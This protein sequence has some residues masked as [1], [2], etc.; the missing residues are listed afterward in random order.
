MRLIYILLWVLPFILNNALFAQKIYFS[1]ESYTLHEPIELIIESP[2]FFNLPIQDVPTFKGLTLIGSSSSIKKIQ[3]KNHYFLHLLYKATQDGKIE[4]PAFKITAAKQNFHFSGKSLVLIQDFPSA[5]K[6]KDKWKLSPDDAILELQFNKPRV[7]VGELL[8]Q[9]VA[10]YIREELH[11]KIYFEPQNLQSLLQSLKNLYFWEETFDS[12]SFKI[13]KGVW[14]NGHKYQKFLLSRSYLYPLQAGS[15]H[16]EP[17][18]LIL[19]KRVYNPKDLDANPFEEIE[20]KSNR[21]GIDII[22][23]PSAADIVGNFNLKVQLEHDTLLLGQS[24]RLTI[25]LYGQGNLNRFVFPSPTSL[26]GKKFQVLKENQQIKLEPNPQNLTS[27]M[28]VIFNLTPQ[29]TGIFKLS[30]PRISYFDTHAKLLKSL[31][32]PELIFFVKNMELPFNNTSHIH[33]FHAQPS[34]TQ[35]S[36]WNYVGIFIIGFMLSITIFL[37]IKSIYQ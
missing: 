13:Q 1:K 21:A 15:I 25:F 18:K 24:N 30:F 3:Q 32:F 34:T 19:K 36:H 14:K 12:L 31:N 28:K 17:L 10:L 7:F 16:Y 8:I 23:L 37:I 4:I 22:A 26:K 33:Q 35:L 2:T 29:D 5:H 27:H 20:I 6:R 11:D 9:E